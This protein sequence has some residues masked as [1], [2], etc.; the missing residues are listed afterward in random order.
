MKQAFVY[1]LNSCL[2]ILEKIPFTS[3]NGLVVGKSGLLL[4]LHHLSQKFQNDSYT[5]KIYDTLNDIFTQNINNYSFGYG[6][7]SFMWILEII[8]QEDILGEDINNIDSILEKECSLMINK[9]NLDYYEGALGI[10]FYFSE[11][12]IAYKNFDLLVY[13]LLQRLELNF[14]KNE[15]YMKIREENG[16]FSESINLGTPHGVTG[17]LL[18]L[19]LIRNKTSLD[20]NSMIIKMCNFLLSFRF[21]KQSSIQ[22]PS[23]VMKN[24][25]K[26]L[27]NIA[28]CYGDLMAAYALLKAGLLLQKNEFIEIAKSTLK[29][30]I[31]RAETQKE[32]LCLCHGYTSLSHIYKQVFLFTQDLTYLNASNR[33]KEKAINTYYKNWIE[34]KKNLDHKTFFENPSLFMGVPGILISIITWETGDERWLKCLLI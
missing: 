24:G 31:N 32:E 26:R 28:W 5:E 34:Y 27:S 33:W 30:T 11:K 7:T 9:N 19:L 8:N 6:I 18:L 20:V 12:K 3:H 4:Y 17:I 29:A 23:R 10:L 21:H 16:E 15:W 2:E 25:E 1:S 13:R 22:F 14:Q